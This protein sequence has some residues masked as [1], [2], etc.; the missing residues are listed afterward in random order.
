MHDKDTLAAEL[1]EIET[2][3]AKYGPVKPADLMAVLLARELSHLNANVTLM[4]GTLA[5]FVKPF[6]EQLN[7]QEVKH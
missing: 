5:E 4:N 6:A 2:V 7:L 3:L 1:S